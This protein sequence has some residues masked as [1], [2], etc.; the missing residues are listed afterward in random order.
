MFI[1]CTYQKHEEHTEGDSEETRDVRIQATPVKCVPSSLY[2]YPN[3]MYRVTPII[4]IPDK[5]DRGKDVIIGVY[6]DHQLCDLGLVIDQ[7][8][9]SDKRLS[10]SLSPAD[11][12]NTFHASFAAWMARDRQTVTVALELTPADVAAWRL[13][14]RFYFR[15][16]MWL[17]KKLTVTFAAGVEA[18]ESEGEFVEL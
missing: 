15:G 16:R 18:M 7:D 2:H 9:H 6:G 3:H 5:A 8:N 10:T 4:A 11:L 1:D 14:N 12:F 17:C 13:F